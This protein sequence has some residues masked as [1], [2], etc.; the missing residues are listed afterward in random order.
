MSA[1]SR[2][3]CFKPAASSS[4][5]S[6]LGENFYISRGAR[7]QIK[8]DALAAAHEFKCYFHSEQIDVELLASLQVGR[9][10][11]NVRKSLNHE[12]LPVSRVRDCLFVTETLAP[13]N[14][15]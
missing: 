7:S 4:R 11:A 9:A 3:K 10:D 15:A 13:M 5:L 8:A 12:L 1:T 2:Q 14:R 6:L